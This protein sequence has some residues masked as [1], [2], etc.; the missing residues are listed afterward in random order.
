M[1][2]LKLEELHLQ[3][4]NEFQYFS[5]WIIHVKVCLHI[6]YGTKKN[7][8]QLF[9]KRFTTFLYSP[10]A[11]NFKSKCAA[12]WL[13]P[14]KGW[15]HAWPQRCVMSALQIFLLSALFLFHGKSVPMCLKFVSS[16]VFFFFF[17]FVL[18]FVWLLWPR[19][20]SLAIKWAVLECCVWFI[21]RGWRGVCLS[22]GNM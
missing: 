4:L 6:V 19:T 5:C 13:Y 9:R 14:S 15:H 22:S 11:G 7:L 8:K 12:K 3:S 1:L 10:L 18:R 20:S 21:H 2:S 17:F 16:L